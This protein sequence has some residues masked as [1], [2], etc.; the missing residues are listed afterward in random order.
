MKWSEHPSCIVSLG[1]KELRALPK[2]QIYNSALLGHVASGHVSASLLT[3]FS[4]EPPFL[5][6]TEKIHL[7]IFNLHDIFDCWGLKDQVIHH[8]KLSSLYC[9]LLFH[10]EKLNIGI[11][12]LIKEK[13]RT[14]LSLVCSGYVLFLWSDTAHSHL[15]DSQL[16]ILQWKLEEYETIS[17]SPGRFG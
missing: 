14:N 7:D 8:R 11:L 5:L 15:K 1:A 17:C 4:P 10:V 16:V 3:L 12:P 6:Q 9:H 13:N 2:C